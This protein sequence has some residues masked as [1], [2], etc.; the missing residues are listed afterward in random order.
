[1]M[2]IKIAVPDMISNLHFP[3]LESGAHVGSPF[4]LNVVIEME[5]VGMR[6]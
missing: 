2:P 3:V 6:T 5:L 4:E 1:M